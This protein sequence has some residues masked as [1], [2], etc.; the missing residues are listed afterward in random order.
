[1]CALAVC[2]M[3]KAVLRPKKSS[4]SPE[5]QLRSYQ[6]LLN[7]LY[8]SVADLKTE[9]TECSFSGADEWNCSL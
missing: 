7:V 6:C 5:A 8:K 1:M 9:P 2:L 3:G 4:I